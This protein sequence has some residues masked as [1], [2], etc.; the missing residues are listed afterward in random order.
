MI[1][2][3]RKREERVTC[4]AHSRTRVPTYLYLSTYAAR[5]CHTRNGIATSD[6]R[7]DLAT[8]RR[9][10][11]S[12]VQLRPLA[13]N[14]GGA[15]ISVSGRARTVSCD[16]VITRSVNRR[17]RDVRLTVSKT[18]GA[19][20]TCTHAR[21][22]AYRTRVERHGSMFDT[23]AAIRFFQRDDTFSLPQPHSPLPTSF[24]TTSSLFPRAGFASIIY[25]GNTFRT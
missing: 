20:S 10:V 3:N 11:S 23:V 22:H 21:M 1:D 2:I 18:F 25:V 5:A 7:L 4:G 6:K 8:T 17:A 16:D 24:P 15:R 13:G 12:F 19:A 14:Q 9:V